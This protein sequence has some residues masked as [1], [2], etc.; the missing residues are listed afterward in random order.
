MMVFID[1]ISNLVF[2]LMYFVCKKQ[3]GDFHKCFL[4]L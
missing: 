2:L 4:L 3:G 1:L